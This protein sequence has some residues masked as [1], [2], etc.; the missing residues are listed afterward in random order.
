VAFDAAR[1]AKRLAAGG[2]KSPDVHLVAPESLDR[3][4][5]PVEELHEATLEGVIVHA[6]TGVRRFDGT[7]CVRGALIAPIASLH[8]AE[9]R[10]RPTL[11][12]GRDE[13][14]SAATVILAVGQQSDVAFLESK[15]GVPIAPW[16]GI[17][18]PGHDGRTAHPA[19]YTA[20]D[21]SVGP[22][23][24]IDAVASGQ[25][26]AASIIADLAPRHAATTDG[27]AVV[28]EPVSME[29][30][31]WSGYDTIARRVLPVLPPTARTAESEVE[32][33]LALKDARREA[34]RCLLCDTHIMLDASRCIACALCVD[35][36]P[37]GCIALVNDLVDGEPADGDGASFELTL[38]EASCIRCGLCV[39]RCP[40][41]ALDLVRV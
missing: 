9:G 3:L 39:D 11:Q 10:F 40:P 12:D 25:R 18:A 34:S 31:Y 4:P 13:V 22:G 33:A 14:L 1:S 37:Y 19:L 26:A 20:G 5:V 23:D 41:H 29:R 28:V 21:V 6:G 36:C 32:H 15:F 30:R 7:D 8:D 35:V 24:L 38:D 27:E 2:G 16:G 17:A